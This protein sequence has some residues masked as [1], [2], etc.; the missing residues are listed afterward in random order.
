MLPYDDTGWKHKLNPIKD[1]S[2]LLGNTYVPAGF[3]QMI[4]VDPDYFDK[5]HYRFDYVRNE[6]LGSVRCLVFDVTP[7]P[8]S[9]DGRFE[10]RIW[11][12]SQD[13]AIVRFNGVF[14]ASSELDGL[15]LALR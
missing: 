1:V 12:E 5:Q 11:V 3:L 10:G 4:F 15:Q 14:V 2:S 9:G 7:L 6:F 13:Y 8:K